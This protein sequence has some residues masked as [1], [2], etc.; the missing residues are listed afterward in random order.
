MSEVVYLNGKLVELAQ[1][2]I[3]PSDQGFLY[4]AG[5][6]ETMRTYNGCIFLLDRHL[7]RLV[8]SSHVVGI[9]NINPAVL[10]RA[11]R[12]VI[13]ANQLE[14]ARVRLMVTRG[15]LSSFSSASGS[16]TVFVQ[17]Q[18][19]E[20][21]TAEKYHLGY[22]VTVSIHPRYSKSTLVCHKTTNYLECLLA[23]VAAIS[24]GNDE[25]LFINEA[26]NLTEGTASNLFLCD[27][28]GIL[29]TPSLDTGILPGITRRFLL[30]IA[31]KMGIET[32][33]TNIHQV[34][35]KNFR[36]AFVTNSLIEV[37][38]VASIKASDG[39]E[40]SFNHHGMANKLQGV[41]RDA[42]RQKFGRYDG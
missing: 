24:D 37:M 14:S 30:E 13:S 26:G 36:E 31:A 33:E 11:C 18:R 35:L 17:A 8:S 23:R 29:F 22:R 5:L 15:S 21:P 25:A 4:G 3:E 20:P 6:F 42:I 19:Y 7:E 2:L 1:A 39:R 12:S 27:Y 10:E 34:D 41:Y 38:P 9:A 32:V 40:Y 28:G 16:P